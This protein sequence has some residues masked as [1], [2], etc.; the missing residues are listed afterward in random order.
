MHPRLAL[1]DEGG[2]GDHGEGDGGAGV[3]LDVDDL[4]VADVVGGFVDAL[5]VRTVFERVGY[6]LDVGETVND[7][8]CGPAL[9]A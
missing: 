8:G 9:V 5:A 2:E 6:V 7:Y 4:V 3:V 1:T